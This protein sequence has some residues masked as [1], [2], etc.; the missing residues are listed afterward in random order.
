MKLKDLLARL[1][2]IKTEAKAIC[3]AA[4]SD[5]AGDITEDQKKVF[6]ALMV[7]KDEVNANIKRLEQLGDMDASAG[8]VTEPSAPANPDPGPRATVHDRAEEDPMRGFA[9]V[10][11]FAMAVRAA[12]ARPGAEAYGLD[13]RLNIG[14]DAP[15][16]FHRETGSSDGFMVPPMIVQTVWDMIFDGEGI[17]NAVAPEPTESNQVQISRDESTP[18][19]STGLQANWASEGVQL[20]PSRLLTEQSN[21]QLHKLHAFVTATEELL[22]DA[23]RLNNRLTKGAAAVIKWVADDAIVLGDGVGKPLGWQTSGALVTIA[24]EAAQAADTIV[25]A[26]VLKMFARLLAIQSRGAFWLA[27]KSTLPQLAVL[28]IGNQPVYTQVGTGIQDM[29]AARLLGMPIVWSEHAQ[30]VGDLNDINLVSPMG[31]YATTKAGGM[32]FAQSMHLFFDFDVQAF[33]WTFRLGGQPYLSAPVT[34]AN[35]GDT[36]SH[37]ITLAARA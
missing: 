2:A 5:N 6:D 8:R 23:P 27:H 32:K 34:P 3:D 20:S 16:N 28:T 17:L 30:V 4:D 26:N 25:S 29:P 24:K 18:W 36:L 13:P 31:Y 7:E 33:R 35:G 37:F 19:S 11:D 10:A 9:H 12:S 1:A 22:S 21:V 15:T 14:A